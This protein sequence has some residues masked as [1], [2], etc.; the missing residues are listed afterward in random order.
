[1]LLLE[2]YL[3][4]KPCTPTMSPCWIKARCIP[5]RTRNSIRSS[6]GSNKTASKS[7]GMGGF[8]AVL[9]TVAPV[10]VSIVWV[11]HVDAVRRCDCS[12]VALRVVL[13][14][15]KAAARPARLPT[16]DD[17]FHFSSLMPFFLW[18]CLWPRQ[19]QDHWCRT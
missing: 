10:S 8:V 17:R 4:T 9:T 2:E 5:G 15:L 16:L 12:K 3:S 19:P 18:V 14:V 13:H 1:M 11:S 6:S 7:I